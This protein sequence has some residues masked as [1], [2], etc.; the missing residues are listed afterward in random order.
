MPARRPRTTDTRKIPRQ[1]QLKH[2]DHA[3]A[4]ALGIDRE[5]VGR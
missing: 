3:V 1:L 5:T 4:R 2:T